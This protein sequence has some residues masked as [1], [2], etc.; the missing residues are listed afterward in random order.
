MMSFELYQKS[1]ETSTLKATST[2]D[3]DLNQKQ[4]NTIEPAI[5]SYCRHI[6]R[7]VTVRYVNVCHR[8]CQCSKTES[9]PIQKPSLSACE[10][11]LTF[12]WR[13]QRN[14]IERAGLVR[15]CDCQWRE[16]VARAPA[17]NCL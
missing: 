4:F 8:C 7:S 11:K 3:L 1:E 15:V 9:A 14:Q 16:R 10:R 5:E 17:V 12:V 13:E 2:L 6:F